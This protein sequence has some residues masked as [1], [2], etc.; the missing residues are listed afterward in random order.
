[1]PPDVF[2]RW[3]WA[4]QTLLLRRRSER[5]GLSRQRAA[6]SNS[7]FHALPGG[8]VAGPQLAFSFERGPDAALLLNRPPELPPAPAEV[9]LQVLF[10]S[11]VEVLPCC[12]AH[13]CDSRLLEPRCVTPSVLTWAQMWWSRSLACA[14]Q[15][16]HLLA[17]TQA[18]SRDQALPLFTQTMELLRNARLAAGR[19][20]S[21]VAAATAAVAGAVG[22]GAGRSASRPARPRPP[23][24]SRTTACGF[25]VS[26]HFAV[27][28]IEMYNVMNFAT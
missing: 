18:Q 7:P 20:S 3:V 2:C 4:V 8:V 12:L 21:A 13:S 6:S 28:C 15:V 9:T 17:I 10:Y 16:G 19:R 27:Q 11:C 22:S 26:N 5:R 24:E 23:K 25:V 14:L 1:M